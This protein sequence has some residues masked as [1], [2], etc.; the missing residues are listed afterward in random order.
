MLKNLK[1]LMN[2]NGSLTTRQSL[3]RN[4]LRNLDFPRDLTQRPQ[5]ARNRTAPLSSRTRMSSQTQ[6]VHPIRAPMAL[7]PIIEK[8]DFITTSI[9]KFINTCYID[10]VYPKLPA[11]YLRVQKQ[12]ELFFQASGVFFSSQRPNHK[13]TPS[14]T[15]MKNAQILIH[16]WTDFVNEFQSVSEAGLTPHF[17]ILSD[18]T[19][20]LHDYLSILFQI[21]Q[22]GT[23]RVGAGQK[24]YNQIKIEVE[25]LRKI[26][27]NLYKSGLL[28]FDAEFN[29]NELE[30]QTQIALSYVN[31]K[32]PQITPR[33]TSN[34]ADI[35]R[36]RMNII[37]SSK[38]IFSVVNGIIGF[39]TEIEI[40][41]KNIIEAS[42]MFSKLFQNLRIP[43]DIKVDFDVAKPPI[44]S[45]TSN[46]IAENQEAKE[47]ISSIQEKIASIQNDLNEFS[48]PKE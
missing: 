17:K 28:S 1:I 29:P 36:T 32:L 31:Q 21:A 4:P 7:R 20:Q 33:L 5:S 16:E 27:S 48:S 10:R 9:Q 30:Q 6:Y 34:S 24:V 15:L 38:E 46:K 42:Q 44:P 47:K 25:K 13:I 11:Q 22:S 14:V 18:T 19:K 43:Y 45:P 23:T 35:Q 8:F 2:Q 26:A 41:R 12:A 39:D 40:T 37:I 3:G